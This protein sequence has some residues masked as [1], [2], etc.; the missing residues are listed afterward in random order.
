MTP[1]ED[2]QEDTMTA[3]FTASNGWQI[4]PGETERVPIM[5]LVLPDGSM[6]RWQGFLRAELTALVEYAATIGITAEPSEEA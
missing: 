3:P 6:A 1:L 2:H 5:N 4:V